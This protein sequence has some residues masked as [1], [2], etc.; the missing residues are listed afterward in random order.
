MNAR[1]NGGCQ[2]P[3]ACF[4]ELDIAGANGGELRLRGLVGSADGTRML[5][6]ESRASG[7]TAE[8]LGIAVAED[9][10]A[11]GAAELL[12]ELDER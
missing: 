2:V 4:A 10:L 9:L 1:L 7:D 8:A 3:I 11:Q 5:R 6:A 12:A